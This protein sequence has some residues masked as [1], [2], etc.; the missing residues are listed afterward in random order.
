VSFGHNQPEFINNVIKSRLV[1]FTPFVLF[2]NNYLFER[3]KLSL[4]LNG[5]LADGNVVVPR[6]LVTFEAGDLDAA[7]LLL[8]DLYERDCL[9]MPYDCPEFDRNAA[10][11]AAGYAFRVCQ[12]ILLRDIGE[13]QMNR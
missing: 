7:G 2:D 6:T 4:F 5:L 1:N 13:A 10:L 8:Q 3:V 11:W 9:E 12:F